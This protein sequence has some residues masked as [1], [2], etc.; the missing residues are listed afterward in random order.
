MRPTRTAILLAGLSA[1]LVVSCQSSRLS[2][3]APD[4]T[5]REWAG[6]E[7][8]VR[9]SDRLYSGGEPEPESF[10]AMRRLG[11][12][13]IISVDGAI[14]DVDGAKD[15]GLTYVHVPIGY[16]GIPA[17][18]AATLRA[19]LA[20]TDDPIYIHCHHGRHRGPAMAAL[21]L[22]MDDAGTTDDAVALM[23]TAGTSRNY[24]G[25]W[26]DVETFDEASLD[27]IDV[28]L[29]PVADVPSLALRMAALDRTWDHIK[30]VRDAGWTTPADHP[31]IDPPH[32]ALMLM[33]HFRES[34]RAAEGDELLN[35]DFF[36]WMRISEADATT[37]MR[38][39]ERNDTAGAEAAYQDIRNSCRACH[40][41]YR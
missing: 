40:D 18:A 35:D 16:D 11:V 10:E 3:D 21:G 33:E 25:L 2:L 23:A 8:V 7:Q 37:L 14:P 12:R 5:P 30:W 29:T 39:L 17:D 31:D 28:T 4:D 36:D 32:E 20:S 27:G 22:M 24:T 26:R 19:A 1:G 13:T 38:A 15:A 41:V 34:I 6:M 9:V